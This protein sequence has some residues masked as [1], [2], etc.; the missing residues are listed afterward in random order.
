MIVYKFP[1]I[2]YRSYSEY[3][4]LTDNRNFGYDTATHSC[5]KVGDLLLSKE[6]SLF[7]AQLSDKPQDISSIINKLCKLFTNV[8]KYILYNDAL[9]F[10]KDLHT[11]GFVFCGEEKDINSSLQQYFSYARTKPFVL[12]L[13][14][15]ENKSISYDKAF[16][17]EY[18]LSQIHVDISSRCNENCMH[19]YIPIKNKCNIMSEEMFDNILCQSVSMNVLNI[20]ISGGEPLLNPLLKS[21]LLKCQEHNFSI[22]LLSNLTLL[23]K[24]LL[25]TI[26][27][28]PLISI[29]TSLYAMNGDIHDSITHNKGSFQKTLH[30]IKLLH[31]H[32]VPLQI[33]CPIMVQNRLYYKDVLEFAVSQNIEA[34]SDYSLFGCYDL[35]KRNLSY[36]L[37]LNEICEIIK[38]DFRQELTRK[39]IKDSA[40]RKKTEPDDAICP[41]CKSS[42]CISNTGDIYPCEGWQ[43][44]TL[45]NLEKQSLK[46]IWE[47]VPMTQ[48]LRFLSYKDFPKCNTCMEKKYCTTCLIMNANENPDGNY[49]KTNPFMCEVAK[50]KKKEIEA[51]I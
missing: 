23:T 22:N 40:S 25:N 6:G 34:S 3:G 28:N 21:F 2:I 9:E 32:N 39:Q 4:Y 13:S 33:N 17:G 38:S 46:Q 51:I 18:H 49:M 35:S 5:L 48:K 27:D 7:Y 42:L 30:A 36:R 31:N 47:Q 16:G 11:R 10:Y 24:D 1:Y 37:P 8:T 12:N 19:C 14:K 15:E 45:G 50:M 20:T 43:G 26:I 29:Q 41:V 44:L